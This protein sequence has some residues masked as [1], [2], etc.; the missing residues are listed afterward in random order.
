MQRRRERVVEFPR[1]DRQPGDWTFWVWAVVGIGFGF[2]VSVIGLITVPASIKMFAV[3][4]R[5]SRA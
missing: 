5:P 3:A 4:P 2:R 1:P